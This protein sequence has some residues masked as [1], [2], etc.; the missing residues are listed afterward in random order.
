VTSWANAVQ[1]CGLPNNCLTDGQG[2]T[3]AISVGYILLVVAQLI[4]RLSLDYL[5]QS[6]V[7]PTAG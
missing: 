6:F 7:L 4:A 3:L 2:K 5:T 1:Q